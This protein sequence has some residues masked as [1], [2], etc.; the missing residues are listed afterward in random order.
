MPVPG[1][2]NY[3][4]D[5]LKAMFAYLRTIP[6]IKNPV[7]EPIPPAPRPAAPSPAKP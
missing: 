7:P 3:T 1:I 6:A 2:N 4:D 5:E